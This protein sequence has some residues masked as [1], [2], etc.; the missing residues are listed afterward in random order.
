YASAKP[1]LAASWT[2]GVASAKDKLRSLV[3]AKTRTLGVQMFGTM[4]PDESHG[5]SLDPGE[6]D[7]FGMPR[8]RIRIDYDRDVICNMV[9]SRDRLMSL[10]AEAGYRATIRDIVPQ[11]YPGTSV[12]YGGTV[13]MHASR[14][15]GVL[16]AWN[17]IYDAPNV[18]V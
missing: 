11:L 15:Y 14:K 9:E 7:E 4:V 18:I 10:L 5:V 13:R 17:R 2:I 16:D 3:P 1:L 8:L 6:S 12:H